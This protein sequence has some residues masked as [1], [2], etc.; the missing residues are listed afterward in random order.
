MKLYK[1]LI[2]G[3]LAATTFNAHSNHEPFNSLKIEPKECRSK[4][5]PLFIGNIAEVLEIKN[6][7][8]TNITVHLEDCFINLKN[9]KVE[10]DKDFAT[11]KTA[12]DSVG[13]IVCGDKVTTHERIA[14]TDHAS[15][16]NLR[17]RKIG[18]KYTHLGKIQAGVLL[19]H[20]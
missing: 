10:F 5:C 3:I 18:D 2:S 20:Y 12:K 1:I 11:L 16:P 7:K 13:E 19:L 14:L 6:E 17:L 4:A 15:R 9:I 8:S